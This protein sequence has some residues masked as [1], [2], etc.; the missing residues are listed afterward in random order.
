MKKPTINFRKLRKHSEIYRKAAE[1]LQYDMEIERYELT[2]C[3]SAFDAIEAEAW[4]KVLYLPAYT[5]E[6]ES[7]IQRAYALGDMLD[8]AQLKFAEMFQPQLSG[9]YW[10]GQNFNKKEQEHR[11]TAL[12]LM[13]DIAKSE[14]N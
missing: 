2:G 5:S 9:V 10:F 14:G 1:L 6:R 3:C 13:A 4:D 12:L 8:E 7:A 11:I